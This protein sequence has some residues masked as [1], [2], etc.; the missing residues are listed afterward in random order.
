MNSNRSFR[1]VRTL[2][3]A[4]GL[5]CLSVGMVRAQGFEGKFTLPEQVRWDQ[6]VLPAG[7]YTFTMD[8]V[9]APFIITL[10]GQG[11]TVM[12]HAT[13]GYD[14]TS[15]PRSELFIVRSGTEAAV[16]SLTLGDLSLIIHY[17]APKGEPPLEAQ[18]PEM[19]QHL[20]ILASVT[21]K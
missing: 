7:N 5:L 8:S 14:T 13:G 6:V 17:Q 2:V 12:V 20:P 11:Q 1:M 9:S 21:G 16:R 18:A 4:G 10:C 15:S 3:L 19:N